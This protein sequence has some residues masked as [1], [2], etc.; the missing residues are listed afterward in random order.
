MAVLDESFGALKRIWVAYEMRR[1]A[2]IP[3]RVLEVAPPTQ[4]A[5]ASK[6]TKRKFEAEPRA[7]SSVCEGA[8][9]PVV[10]VGHSRLGKVT[11]W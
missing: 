1:N 2:V 7:L 6:A 3:G 8:E 10:W 9:P 5:L 11:A 4:L